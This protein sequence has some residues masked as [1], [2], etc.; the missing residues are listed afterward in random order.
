MVRCQKCSRISPWQTPRKNKCAANRSKTLFLHF[1]DSF[2]GQ[3]IAWYRLRELFGYIWFF[4][5]KR[6]SSFSCCFFSQMTLVSCY[7]L[8]GLVNTKLFFVNLSVYVRKVS[9]R[10]QPKEKPSTSHWKKSFLDWHGPLCVCTISCFAL[11]VIFLP[12]FYFS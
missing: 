9:P 10:K 11:G 4:F 2:T 5:A 7:L 12:K 6:C 1:A 8:A 3:F